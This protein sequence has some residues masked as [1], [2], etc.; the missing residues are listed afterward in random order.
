MQDILFLVMDGVLADF[1]KQA[2]LKTNLPN[3]VAKIDASFRKGICAEPL[4]PLEKNL[5]KVIRTQLLYEDDFWR[6]MPVKEGAKE[7]FADLKKRFADIRILSHLSVPTDAVERLSQIRRLKAQWFL[8]NIDASFDQSKILVTERGLESFMS[9]QKH[10]VLIDSKVSNVNT[11]MRHYM[12]NANVF[13][14]G[15]SG[16]VFVN[17]RQ[18]LDELDQK[19]FKTRVAPAYPNFTFICLKPQNERG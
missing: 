14:K 3:T 15:S 8:K 7:L 13:V 2:S 4:S 17:N 10:N 12:R 11:W 18:I 5:K 19:G 9:A 1:T 6:S 16:F